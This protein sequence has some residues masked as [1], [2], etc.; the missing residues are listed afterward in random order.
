MHPSVHARKSPRKPALIM[1]GSGEVTSYE[2]LDTRSNQIAHLFRSLGLNA[3]DVV[4]ILLENHPRLLEIAWAAQ[5]SGL[6]F[7]CVSSRLAPSEIDYI[8]RDSGTKLLITS[9][10]LLPSTR[11]LPEMLPH[12]RMMMLG[13]AAPGFTAFES[14]FSVMP[15]HPIA[16]EQPGGDMLYSS[17]TTGRPKGVRVPL[18][19]GSIEHPPPLL[20]L[21]QTIFGFDSSSIY[22]CPAPLYHAAPLRWSMAVQRLGGTVVLMD[23]FDPEL[24][25]RLIEKYKVNVSQWVPTHFVRMLKMPDETRRRYDLSSLRAAVHAAAPCPVPVK[26]SM[27]DWWG[28]ILF[29][30][31]A[32]TEG[33]G[34][35]VIS[36][37]EWL[38]KPG[39]VGRAVFGTVRIC[40]EAGQPLPPGEEGVIYFEGG[41]SFE[42]HNDPAK[43]AE[44]RNDRGWTTLGDIGRLDEEEFLFIT[45]RKSFKSN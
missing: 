29:E 20:G 23:K 11:T 36:S 14:A 43:T 17:G 18:P 37:S 26:R 38:R 12:V 16:D 44:S 41:A 27:I 7:V 40:D 24:A 28:P 3:G 8:L 2:A 15:V 25:L 22:L 9:S 10:A 32:G 33:N 35:T 13:D 39:S 21:A 34:M 5:R 19:D 31:Y 45:D 30:Y 4:G 42:Y 1:G 6:Y